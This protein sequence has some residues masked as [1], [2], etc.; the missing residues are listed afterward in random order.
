MLKLLEFDEEL[1]NV[2][3]E[4]LNKN[5]EELAMNK[6]FDELVLNKIDQNDYLNGNLRLGGVNLKW[7]KVVDSQMFV[8]EKEVD[9]RPVLEMRAR[10]N[11]NSQMEQ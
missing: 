9:L 7:R 3:F 6:N 1:D 8:N 5:F 2:I 11:L 4:V 10:Y